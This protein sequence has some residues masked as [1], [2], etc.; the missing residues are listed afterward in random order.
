MQDKKV[1]EYAVIRIVPRVEREEFINV[2]VV[3]FCKSLNFIEVKIEVN[4]QKLMAFMPAEE[5]EE[6]QKYLQS[7]VR[8]CNGEKDAGP[9][10]QLPPAE[11]FRWST[12]MRS[13][14]VQTSRVHPGI[15]TDPGQTIQHLFT[16]LVL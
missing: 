13:T 15:C 4:A 2:G 16:Q 8:I 1:F 5:F 9:I 10:A 14:V 7:F 3:L 6:V 11:R 12:A